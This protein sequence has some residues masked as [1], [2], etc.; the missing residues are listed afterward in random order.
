MSSNEWIVCEDLTMIKIGDI[1]LFKT[2]PAV[3]G[4]TILVHYKPTGELL[5]YRTKLPNLTVCQSILSY[6]MS[7]ENQ[8]APEVEKESE[9][10]EEEEEEVLEDEEEE[11]HPAE[12]SALE[13]RRELTNEMVN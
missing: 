4:W 3:E 1:G 12:P 13:K 10:G 7:L 8:V 11:E 9:T 2:V 6:L 5:P